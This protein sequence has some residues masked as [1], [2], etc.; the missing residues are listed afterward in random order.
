VLENIEKTG[1]LVQKGVNPP[2]YTHKVPHPE[3]EFRRTIYLPVLRNGYA[4]ADTTRGF[5]DFV[6]PA[7]IA[8]QRAQTVVPTQ[9]LFLLNNEWLRKRAGTLAKHVMAAHPDRDGRLAELWRRVFCR[10]LTAAERDDASALLDKLDPL[11]KNRAT[12]ESVEWQELC[13]GLLA[14]N[15]FIYR[16]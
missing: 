2:S 11:L 15:E 13:H 1:G 14:A 8:G 9:A 7:E 12:A 16:L 3:E 6:S 10:A 4:T 5:F